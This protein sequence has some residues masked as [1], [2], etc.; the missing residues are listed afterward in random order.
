M[1]QLMDI[2][3]V[4]VKGQVVVPARIRERFG[5]KR[6]TRVAFIEED[7][8][9]VMQ[10]LDRTYFASLKGITGTRGRVLKSLLEEKKVERER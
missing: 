7:G 5:I 3:T 1:E 6:G 10:P 4:T 8:K 2:S 9:L